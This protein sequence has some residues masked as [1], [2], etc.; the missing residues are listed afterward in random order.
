MKNKNSAK[1]LKWPGMIAST[2]LLLAFL[3]W[4][5]GYYN[6]LRVAITSVSIYYVYYLD[7]TLEKQNFW[8]WSLIGIAI[9]FNPI[10][11]VYLYDK[12]VWE[13]ID[14]VVVIFFMVFLSKYNKPN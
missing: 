2:M 14:I 11:P 3:D 8:F 12:S 10:I 13:I 5:Y 9:L 7:T 6:L 4:S 1:F